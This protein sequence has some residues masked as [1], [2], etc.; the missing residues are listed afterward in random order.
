MHEFQRVR[1]L[2]GSIPWEHV[3]RFHTREYGPGNGNGVS[4]KTAA[5]T[6]V[7]MRSDLGSGCSYTLRKRKYRSIHALP[8]TNKR[9]VD[10]GSAEVRNDTGRQVLEEGT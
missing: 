10:S 5:I 4:E 1:D 8:D 7:L 2:I 6:G 9:F 3:K